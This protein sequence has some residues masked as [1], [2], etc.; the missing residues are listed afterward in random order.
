MPKQEVNINF[1]QGLDQKTDPKQL[2]PGKFLVLKNRVFTKDKLLQKRNGFGSLAALP[3]TTSTYCTTFSGNLTAIG[4]KIRA[5]ANGSQSWINKGTFQPT[6][7]SV[8]PVARSAYNQ[9]QCD[10]VI[11]TTG[12]VC[13]VY[14]EVNNGVSA[15]YYVVSDSTTGQNIVAPTVIPVASGVITGAPRVFLLNG[16]FVMVFTNVIAAANHL[17]YVAISASNPATVV[18]ANTDV[19]AVYDP[20]SSVSWDGV[21]VDNRLFIAYNTSSGGQAVKFTYL[22]AAFTVATATSFAASIGTTMSVCADISTPTHPVIYATFWDSAGSTGNSVAILPNLNKAMSATQWLATGTISNVATAA[23]NGILTILYQNTN[24]YGYDSNIESDFLSVNTITLPAT[25]TTG[26]LGTASNIVRSL[27][28]GSKAFVMSGA[29]YAIASYQSALQP[30]YF[31][32]N[33]SGQAIARFAYQNGGGYLLTGLPQAQVIG[34]TVSMPYLFKDLVVSVNKAQGAATSSSVYSQ[35][36]VNLMSIEFGSETL[37]SAEIGQNLNLSG[38]FLYSYDGNTINEQ[39]FHIYPENIETTAITDPAPTGDVTS[40]SP[41]IT[42][43]SANTNIVVGMNI[44]GTSIPANTTVLAVGSTTVT[45]S[46]NATGSHSSETITFTGNVSAQQYYYQVIYQWTDAQGNVFNSAPSVATGN[47]PGAGHS[48]IKIFVPTCRI[49]YKPGVK[50]IIYRWSA[51]QSSYYQITSI[52]APTI[53]STT[54]DYITFVDLNSDAQIIGNSLIYTT[55]GVV[56]N[57]GGAAFTAVTLFDTRLWGIDAEDRNK[58]WYSKQVIEA[59][60]VEMSDL[61]TFFISPNAGASQNTGPLECIFPMDDKL[62]LMKANALYYISGAGPDNL[63][64]NSQYS[65]P[66]FIT[67]TVGSVNQRSIVFVPACPVWTPGGMA[68]T[69]GGLIFQSDK[70]IWILTRDLQ[71]YYIGA[72]VEDANASLITSAVTVPETTQVRFTLD[73]GTALMFDY[74]YGQWGTFTNLNA[75]SST[76]YQDLH[77]YISPLGNVSQETPGIYLDN[78]SPVLTGFTTGWFNF[79]SLQ[80]YQRFLGFYFLGDYLSPHKIYVSIAY[81]YSSSPFQAL[82]VTPDNFSSAAA[83][84]FGDQPAPFGAPFK[85]EDWKIHAKIQK[86]TAFQITMEEFYDPSFGGAPGAGLT[87]SGLNLIVL[88]KRGSRPIRAANT[89]G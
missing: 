28:L 22:D 30:T 5:Y 78:G 80:G 2:M 18:K 53:S 24:N 55:G 57:V 54:S 7:L 33:S 61:F 8:L 56:E 14:T 81:N 29:V 36:G 39:N 83:S 43:L 17:Q 64:S 31:L 19:A 26:S 34:T 85:L 27:G 84:P 46:H 76:I 62:I 74:Y 51:S 69:S 11:S 12:F 48:S 68:M 25:V 75:V 47:S 37:N 70:G 79:A 10:S 32:I 87:L 15:Y 42:N 40:G 50:I 73:N 6:T 72:P 59:T 4:N 20:A 82:T 21:V 52:T 9:T 63:G 71:T 23:Q 1:A 60:P 3:D 45:M 38:G 89:A 58:L 16:L 13:T 67:S 66:I 65:E 41:T 86:C 44:S 77:T 88:P 49:T 35:T